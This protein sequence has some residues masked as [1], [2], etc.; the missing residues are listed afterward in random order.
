MFSDLF[1]PITN[2]APPPPPLFCASLVPVHAEHQEM[3]QYVWPR[4]QVQEVEQQDDVPSVFK[5][6]VIRLTV[7][8][9]ANLPIL[10]LI[11]ELV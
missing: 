7:I 9:T 2:F 6:I 5:L 11:L 3:C 8:N 1:P 10:L 4:K